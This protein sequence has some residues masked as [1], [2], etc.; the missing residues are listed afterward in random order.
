MSARSPL[1][2]RRACCAPNLDYLDRAEVDPTAWAAAADTLIV[3]DAG[4]DLYRLR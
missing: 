1:S 4:E 2:S 3:A